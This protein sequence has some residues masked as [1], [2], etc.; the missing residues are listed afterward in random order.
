MQSKRGS[1]FKNVQKQLKFD[2]TNSI[3]HPTETRE[4]HNIS[5]ETGQKQY[6]DHNM[7]KYY[8]IL[9]EVKV[10]RSR[11]DVKFPIAKLSKNQKDLL[12]LPTL[13]LSIS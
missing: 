4:E 10:E 2:I 1:F 6:L 7:I 12:N 8:E 3:L 11:K 13:S 9:N 5:R